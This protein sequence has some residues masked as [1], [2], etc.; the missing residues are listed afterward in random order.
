LAQDPSKSR[1]QERI[2]TYHSGGI[3]S[4]FIIS[5][6]E[7]INLNDREGQYAY[8]SYGSDVK[9]VSPFQRRYRKRMNVVAICVSLFVPWLIFITSFAVLSFTLRYTQPGLCFLII[10][11]LG[12]LVLILGGLAADAVAKRWSGE[13][14]DPTWYL[15]LFLTSLLAWAL[16]VWGGQ[17]NYKT[18]MGPFYDVNNL[19]TYTL[20]DPATRDGREVMD[21]GRVTF[22]AGTR[23]DLNKAI[24]FKNVDTYCVA[25]ISKGPANLMTYD[26]WAVGI[27][28]CS[29]NEADFRCGDYNNPGV[30]A[31]LR[32]M[33]DSERPFF[34]LAVQQAEAAFNIKANHPLFY[35]WTQDPLSAMLEYQDDGYRNFMLGMFC[36]FGFQ[37]LLVVWAALSFAKMGYD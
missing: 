10:A 15:F 6:M 20:I 37:T 8:G 22:M 36:H 28:C 34:R 3:T 5:A 27:N 24:G 4:N 7:D 19:N 12:V 21:G 13:A 23:L 29:G 9:V 11:A 1:I 33:Q 25:P 17:W 18:Q 16:G 2:S 30:F 14:R 31:G 35:Y 26:F 32:L